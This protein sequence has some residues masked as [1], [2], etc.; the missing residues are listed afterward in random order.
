VN[1]DDWSVVEW[2]SELRDLLWSQFRGVPP[3]KLERVMEQLKEELRQ[4]EV[5]ERARYGVWWWATT[6]VS[7]VWTA[8]QW[9]GV[10]TYGAILY[11]Q[12]YWMYRAAQL[13]RYV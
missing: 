11:R 7:T 12:R 9:S 6:A 3:E 1:V 5:A 10:V 8:Y 13:L 4:E 2:D